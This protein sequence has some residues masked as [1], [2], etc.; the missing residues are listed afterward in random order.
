MLVLASRSPR[1]A[2]LLTRAGFAFTVAP[3]D[4]DEAPRSGE[5]P[6]ALVA[7][8]ARA[9]AS[10]VAVNRPSAVVVGADTL[11]V[12][13]AKTLGK[14]VDAPDATA[15]LHRLSGRTHEVL[16]GVAVYAGQHQL[17]DVASSRVTMRSLSE[18]DIGWYVDSEEPMGKA[19]GY[20]IQ[21]L[22]S[23][24]VVGIEGSYTNVVGLPIE[25]L[26]RLLRAVG[27][28]GDAGVPESQSLA[29]R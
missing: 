19:G 4:V 6:H 14:P 1:R 8:L 13:D 10:A 12:V 5:A 16:T 9:K 15:M 29:L 25:L 24:F 27:A 21:G 2:E 26:D 17:C 22:A 28:E 11:V 18:V 7:R 23:R 3:A 20:A